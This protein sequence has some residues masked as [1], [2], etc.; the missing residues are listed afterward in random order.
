MLN[1]HVYWDPEGARDALV[2]IGWLDYNCNETE[3]TGLLKL[4]ICNG[5]KFPEVDHSLM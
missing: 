5:K 2:K 4:N 3:A 1:S